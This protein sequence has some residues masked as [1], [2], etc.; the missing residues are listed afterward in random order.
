MSSDIFVLN[1]K[2]KPEFVISTENN[3]TIVLDIT[4]NEE[5]MYEGLYRE[6]VRQAQILRKE[7]NFEID[8]RISMQLT[9]ESET[10][11]KV[12]NKFEDKIKK[13]VLV[14]SFGHEIVNPDIVKVVEV[15]DENIQITLKRA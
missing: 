9:T 1:Y 5:L 13:E 10:L 7:A 6:L 12:I 15:G 3:I 4:I 2:A 8:E 14:I 11:Q